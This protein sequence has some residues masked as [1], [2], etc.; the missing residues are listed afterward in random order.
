MRA[1]R[2]LIKRNPEVKPLIALM[3][4]ASLFG[5]AMGVYRIQT[6]PDVRMR[7]KDYP[8]WAPQM[9]KDDDADNISHWNTQPQ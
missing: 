8:Y 9:S 2:E 5:I 3:A 1:L 7:N 4:G 6:D